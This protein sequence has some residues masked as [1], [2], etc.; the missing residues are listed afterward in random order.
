MLRDDR[1]TD[2]PQQLYCCRKI[3]GRT[4][5]DP[6][7]FRILSRVSERGGGKGPG[8][9]VEREFIENLQAVEELVETVRH[10]GQGGEQVVDPHYGTHRKRQAGRRPLEHLAY[11]GELVAAEQ[12]RSEKGAAELDSDFTHVGRGAGSLLPDVLE[13][14]PGN[15]RKFVISNLFHDNELNTLSKAP[16]GHKN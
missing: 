6:A 14:I 10:T 16:Y 5:P 13:I 9:L 15:E 3:F 2:L 11:A 12:F 4:Y 1:H 8:V 7:A